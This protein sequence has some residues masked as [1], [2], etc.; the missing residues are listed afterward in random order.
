MK[1]HTEKVTELARY[2]AEAAEYKWSAEMLATAI[3]AK[4][5]SMETP[6]ALR[7]VLDA[8]V[9]EIMRLREDKARLIEAGDELDAR[10]HE[11]MAVFGCN[12][13][14]DSKSLAWQA[15]KEGAK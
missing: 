13:A 8:Q 12:V 7:N 4:V 5:E 1:T 6:G 14:D 2:L 11:R 3:L 9:A 10:M 15:A